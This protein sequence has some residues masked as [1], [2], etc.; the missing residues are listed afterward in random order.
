MK[1]IDIRKKLKDLQS[2]LNYASMWKGFVPSPTVQEISNEIYELM[3]KIKTEGVQWEVFVENGIQ[4]CESCRQP[5]SIRKTRIISAMISGLKKWYDHVMKNWTQ[6]FMIRD[7]DLETKE[8]SV[9]NHL[10]RFGLLYKEE[11]FRAGEYGVRRKLVSKF[12]KWEWK[13]SVYY[14]TD[15]TKREWEEWR[16][17]MSEERISIDEI[18]NVKELRDLYGDKLTEYEWNENFE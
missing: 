17:T 11:W 7:L 13:V 2:R 5:I 3:T 12:F 15:P 8:Y 6:T 4:F 1:E 10:V 16:R 18:P 14:E 9:L